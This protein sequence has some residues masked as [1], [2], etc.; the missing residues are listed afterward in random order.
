LLSRALQN[1]FCRRFDAALNDLNLWPEATRTKMKAAFADSI[2]QDYPDFAARLTSSDGMTSATASNLPRKINWLKDLSLD[3]TFL[4]AKLDAVE[5]KQIIDQVEKT[6][7]DVPDS[8]ESELRVRRVSLGEAEGLIVRGTQLLC[9]GTGNC[10]T[11]VFRR[12]Q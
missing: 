3:E 11:W 7:F 9:G 4:A 10:E 5:R 12:S 2:K 8:W 6:S 1:V